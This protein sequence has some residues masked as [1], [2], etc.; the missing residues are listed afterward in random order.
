MFDYDPSIHSGRRMDSGILIGYQN[1]GSPYFLPVDMFSGHL[2]ITG[3]TGTGKSSYLRFLIKNMDDVPGNL[4]IIDPHGT[5]MD[6][7]YSSRRDLVYLGL[8][9]VVIDGLERKM[10]MNVLDQ[11][12][13]PDMVA[14]WIKSIFSSS[15]FSNNTWGPR[16]DVMFR[17]VLAEYIRDA[18][19]PTL[20]DFFSIIAS[21]VRTRAFISGMQDGPVKDLIQSFISDRAYWREY[22]ASTLNKI[23]PVI[24][25]MKLSDLVSSRKSFDLYSTMSQAGK[26]VF[27][28][29]A[30]GKM[31]SDVSSQVSYLIL[32]KIWFDSLRRYG[33]GR[34]VNTYIFVD[35]AQNIPTGI[36]ETI[37]S[38][39]RKYGM[40]LIL[41]NQYMDQASAYQAALF[42]NVRN[43]I[44]FQ[45]SPSD[46]VILS[47]TVEERR[48]NHMISVLTSQRLHKFTAWSSDQT[49]GPATLS[50][51]PPVFTPDDRI[52]KS[53]IRYGSEPDWTMEKDVQ[54]SL[55]SQ[56]IMDF[57]RFLDMNG[58][59]VQFGHF[60]N[61]IPDAHFY[62]DGRIYMVEAEVSDM[63]HPSR[64]LEKIRN[65][66]NY[67]LIFITDDSRIEEL[68]KILYERRKVN[69][70]GTIQFA[71]SVR[72]HISDISGIFE[73]VWIVSA[74]GKPKYHFLGKNHRFIRSVL[75]E[76][77]F[78]T[79]L[80]RV[81][82]GPTLMTIYELMKSRDTY[83][84]TKDEII[85]FFNFDT[86]FIESII[87]ENGIISLYDIFLNTKLKFH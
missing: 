83:I 22:T 27:V 5:L 37:L 70:D 34:V 71:G 13:D 51:T 66:R 72:S 68:Y 12:A 16:L 2:S 45:V 60:G 10:M 6:S 18:E 25:S 75:E 33:N 7:V 84:F 62:L 48:R 79:R 50:F 23:I 9:S 40:R 24:S 86:D 53:I 85:S 8:D 38:E 77:P 1:D 29:V 81:R 44:S 65:Y 21:P 32:M 59:K 57:A 58:I 54:T 19:Y 11:D 80:K 63:E 47:R 69:I 46:A 36:L 14:G 64:I 4:V 15:S 35:E 39:G 87:D 56:L 73:R 20:S 82:F 42:G 28:D 61:L 31:P 26:L 76:S 67:N 43:Y 52:Q 3:K 17:S 41:S 30:K 55:H 78:M 49:L 74:Q